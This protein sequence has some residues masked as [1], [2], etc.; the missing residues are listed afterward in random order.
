MSTEDIGLFAKLKFAADGAVSGMGRAQSA[1]GNLTKHAKR[2]KEG[3]RDLKQGFSGF[4][5]VATAVAGVG[6]LTVRKFAQFE[7]RFGAVKAV[8]GKDATP[9]FA[10]LEQQAQTLGSTTAF[11]AAQAA[12]AME[13]LAR[14]GMSATE[15]MASIGPVL[16]AAAAEGMDL[17]DAA[18]IV[19]SNMKAFGL[20]ASDATRIA[21]ALAYVSAKTNTNMSGLQ[22]GMKFVAPVAAQMGIELEDTAA[23]LGVLADVGLKGTLAGTGLKNA[24]LKIAAGAKAGKVSVGKFKSEVVMAKDAMGKVTGVNLPATLGNVVVQLK[25]IDDPLKR[26]QAMMKLL[27]IRG[28]GTAGAFEALAKNPEKIA[29]LF[30][31]MKASAGGKALEMAETRLDNIHGDFVRISSAV[32]GLQ[33]AMGKM[34][35]PAVQK[36]LGGSGGL[37]ALVGDAAKAFQAMAG[38]GDAATLERNLAGLN[39]TSVQFVQ[40]LKEGWEGA[41]TIAGVTLTI[42]K[43]TVDAVR[44]LISPLGFMG[45]Q[46]SGV[47]GYTAMAIKALALGAAI[48]VTTGAFGRLMSVTRGSLKLLAGGLGVAGSAAKGSI[49]FITKYMPTLSK[50]LPKGLGALTNATKALDKATAQP[51]RVVNFDEMGGIGGVGGA[52]VPGAGA[53]PA[54]GPGGRAGNYLG[55]SVGGFGGAT[56]RMGKIANVAGKSVGVLGAAIAGWQLGRMIDETLGLS[57]AISDWA[58]GVYAAKRRVA[59]HGGAVAES[60]AMDQ[61]KAL[62]AFSEKGQ[63]A[64]LQAEGPMVELSREVV[65]E[66][67]KK[68]V[69][70]GVGT[71]DQKKAAMFAIESVL[72]RIPSKE[73]LQLIALRPVEVKVEIDGRKVGQVTAE[74]GLESKGRRKGAKAAG[75]PGTRRRAK[76]G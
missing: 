62:L 61:A 24:L 67:L 16:N 6:A 21:D 71:A 43:G 46:G 64:Q 13:N 49:G 32:D 48:K 18:D 19:A 47:K 73:E 72:D 27:G 31:G 29:A 3:V 23:A 1:F 11:T 57:D 17:A 26:A 74:H 44:G 20:Q 52:G 45:E 28:M 40:G 75:K 39:Q 37:T 36:A 8:L 5:M 7:E 10:A 22:E 65:R 42:F 14:S 41:K 58:A 50:V 9:A 69:A 33:N 53:S 54:A 35:A 4:G 76:T 12:E 70:Q 66:H 63:K 59:E 68:K 55:Q 34:L 38:S 25:R 2:A 30:D 15:I 51:V 56:S 60:G